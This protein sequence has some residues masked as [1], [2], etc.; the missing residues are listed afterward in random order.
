MISGQCKKHTPLISIIV[1]IYNAELTLERC[2][3]SL[4]QQEFQDFEIILIDD[5]STDNSS[6][7]CE[8]Y[9]KTDSRTQVLKQENSGVS[10][11]RNKGIERATGKYILF[12]D[13]DDSLEKD[14]LA[15]YVKILSE[16]DPDAI[17]GALSIISN[18]GKFTKKPK[19]IGY[20][21]SDI[22]NMI[23]VDSEAFG[24]AGGKLFRTSIIKKNSL[25]FN[26]NMKSQEDLDFC[27]SVYYNCNSFYLTDYDG[28]N[29]Y[30]AESSREPAVCDYISNQLK[31]ISLARVKTDLTTE[32]VMAVKSRILLLIYT[33]FYDAVEC[34]NYENAVRQLNSVRGLRE[35][36]NDTK[37]KDEK[38]LIAKW[39]HS[40]NYRM[41]YYYY[42]IRNKIRDAFRFIFSRNKKG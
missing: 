15:M 10:A 31:L 42:I 9:Q 35:Y 22:W 24:W 33:Y 34:K 21:T 37:I 36:L 38:T 18:E 19:N 27:I 16:N 32:A 8:S 17:V 11:A 2:I 25:K 29:Y 5:G 28:Y 3:D 12:V 41:I 26:S 30:Y 39:Y 13:S 7:I 20:F 23:C 6:M 1:P 40:R 4:L 14:M